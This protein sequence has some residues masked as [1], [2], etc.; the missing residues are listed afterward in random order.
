MMAPTRLTLELPARAAARA[1]ATLK[2]H[3]TKIDRVL[4]RRRRRQAEIDR[5]TTSTRAKLAELKAMR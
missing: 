1:E 4:E 3:L 2:E 5:L